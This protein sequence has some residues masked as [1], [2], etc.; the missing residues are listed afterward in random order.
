MQGSGCRCRLGRSPGAETL[1]EKFP[2]RERSAAAT[3]EPRVTAIVV[4]RAPGASWTPLELCLRSALA[5]PS[6]DELVIVDMGADAVISSALRAFGAD[7]RDVKLIAARERS[8]A[9]A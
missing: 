2:S 7:R 8:S 4:V 9:A 3:L 5:E 6:I 1:V